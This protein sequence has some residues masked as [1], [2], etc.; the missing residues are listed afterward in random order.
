MKKK[1]AL[2]ATTTAIMLTFALFTRHCK[3]CPKSPF[4]TQ[5]LM[6]KTIK[7]QIVTAGG[8]HIQEVLKVGS[9]VSGIVDDILVK[10][11]QLV[12]K[13]DII[14]HINLGK[15]DSDYQYAYHTY[16]KSLHNYTY[17]KNFFDRQEKLYQ[18]K[19][20]SEDLYQRYAR[21]RDS[22]FECMKANEAL[23]NKT[24]L[25]LD[26]AFIK[27]PE[28]GTIITLNISKGSAVIN[29]FQNILCEIARDINALEAHLDI[30]E[31]DIPHIKLGQKV[32]ITF[33]AFPDTTI[34]GAIQS[35][36]MT[37]RTAP[38][39][40]DQSEG[41]FFKAIVPLNKSK[42]TIMPG[43]MAHASITIEKSKAIPTL[44]AT[45]FHLNS[46]LIESTAAHFD[47]TLLPCSKEK[48]K[49]HTE[50][51]IKYVWVLQDNRLE[52]RAVT[53]GITDNADWEIKSGITP[54]DHVVIDI[55]EHKEQKSTGI[56][57]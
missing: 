51:C 1:I 17:Q 43:M 38:S 39:P 5:Q 48:R 40:K 21:D 41:G 31:S 46:N 29:D 22:A 37:P 44:H 15:D 25:E 53:V 8:I 6:T 55:N 49:D 23:M 32:R 47:Y 36:S 9:L 18:A 3:K 56:F 42:L 7:K 26:N 50:T 10:E 45:A 4:I 57:S 34:K 54:E 16:R 28:A 27:A 35:I 11:N 33:N 2:F 24:K 52:E 13:N 14:A 30:D 19:Q 20:I 12:K